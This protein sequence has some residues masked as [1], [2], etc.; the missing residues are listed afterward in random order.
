[1]EEEK[2]YTIEE[3][4]EMLKVVY[5]TIYRWI[6]QGKLKAFRVGKKYMIKKSD[7]EALIEKSKV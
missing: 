4:A 3:V 1:M 7:I 5:M 6:K 2:Y